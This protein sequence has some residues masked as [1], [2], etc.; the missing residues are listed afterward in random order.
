M[1]S[2]GKLGLV[3]LLSLGYLRNAI[4]EYLGFELS[5]TK[6]KEMAKVGTKI[7]FLN[8]SE[9]TADER[10]VYASKIEAVI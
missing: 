3:R 8:L 10:L 2:I 5:L 4:R 9:F 7:I 6:M 1:T